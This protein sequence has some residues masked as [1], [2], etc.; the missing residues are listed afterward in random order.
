MRRLVQQL[1]I[2]LPVLA[3]CTAVKPEAVLSV[4]A[5]P[6]PAVP[7]MHAPAYVEPEYTGPRLPGRWGIYVDGANVPASFAS[8][9]TACGEQRHELAAE[10]VIRDAVVHTSRSA[11]D[12]TRSLTSPPGT[13][14]QS[15]VTW[16]LA[17][18]L[19]QADAGLEWDDATARPVARADLKAE[20]AVFDSRGELVRRMT[21]RAAAMSDYGSGCDNGAVLMSHAYRRASHALVSKIVPE[22]GTN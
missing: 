6:E 12:S 5:A 8:S 15:G 19:L 13:G 7:A 20:I 1:L 21:E 17:I 14:G 18:R 4:A 22:L 16:A 3:S 10:A 2:V 9:S 11:F